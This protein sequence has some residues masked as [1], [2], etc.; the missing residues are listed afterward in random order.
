[1]F[2]SLGPTEQ[3]LEMGN[4]C[5]KKSLP[6]TMAQLS[7]AFRWP[8]LVN[9]LEARHSWLYRWVFK[10]YYIFKVVTAGF[11]TCRVRYVRVRYMFSTA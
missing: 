6:G 11:A 7:M 2:S 3:S 1:M 5:F 9:T 10:T 8:S 4:C